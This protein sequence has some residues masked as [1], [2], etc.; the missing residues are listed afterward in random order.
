[1]P[2]HAGPESTGAQRLH[3]KSSKNSSRDSSPHRI[4]TGR[5]NSNQRFHHQGPPHYNRFNT[6][7]N[8]TKAGGW[9]PRASSWDAK[10][11]PDA[12]VRE[13]QVSIRNNPYELLASSQLEGF[14][15]DRKSSSPSKAAV[16]PGIRRSEAKTLYIGQPFDWADDEDG[17]AII[18]IDFDYACF[19]GLMTQ[20]EQ[21]PCKDDDVS[22]PFVDEEQSRAM[23]AP[24]IDETQ[25]RSTPSTVTGVTVTGVT[26]EGVDR[27]C[28]LSRGSS[29]GQKS[30]GQ[31]RRKRGKGRKW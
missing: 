9:H 2:I 1:M 20:P 18:A 3:S 14:G 24:K 13:N 10:S 8:R 11:L 12:P 19:L 6:G 31:R 22:L 16:P 21:K 7:Q 28:V 29:N 17:M 26:V 27:C 15:S 4:P 25:H 23:G 5:W 30:G